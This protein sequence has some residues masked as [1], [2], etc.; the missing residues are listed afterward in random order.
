MSSTLEPGGAGDNR[1]EGG[2]SATLPIIE[3]LLISSSSSSSGNCVSV[4]RAG[5]KALFDC[6]LFISL[7]CGGEMRLGAALLVSGD[8]VLKRMVR[9]DS[10]CKICSNLSI[11]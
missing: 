6:A 5:T 3:A 4:I 8:R 10:E 11:T 2:P 7:L 9:L 1:E